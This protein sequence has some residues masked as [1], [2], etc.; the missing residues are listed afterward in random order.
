MAEFFEISTNRGDRD[1]E[2]LSDLA[3]GQVTSPLV[4]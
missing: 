1:L 3:L 2:S 4:V